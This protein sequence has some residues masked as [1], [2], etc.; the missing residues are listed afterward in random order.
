M[1]QQTI[2]IEYLTIFNLIS[3]TNNLKTFIW[4]TL[5][6][7]VVIRTLECQELNK[8]DF[9]TKLDSYYLVRF[10]Y[11]GTNAG[12]NLWLE[13][14]NIFLLTCALFGFIF[15]KGICINLYKI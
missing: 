10:L 1:F 5:N 4:N 12:I 11:E 3:A 2:I 9:Q 6:N 7:I 15:T 13:F 8:E 14:L